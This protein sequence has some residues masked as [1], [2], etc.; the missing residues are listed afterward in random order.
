MEGLNF[1]EMN[2][3]FSIVGKNRKSIDSEHQDSNTERKLMILGLN[4]TQP[5]LPIMEDSKM[6]HSNG[7]DE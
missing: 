3:T 6:T 1:K 7:G 2:N 4:P 5:S